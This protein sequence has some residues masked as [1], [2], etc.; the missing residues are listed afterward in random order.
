MICYNIASRLAGRINRYYMPQ[1]DRARRPMASGLV[2]VVTMSLL[3][4]NN[5]WLPIIN[6]SNAMNNKHSLAGV[7]AGATGLPSFH[8]LDQP[9][10]IEL[11]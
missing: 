2:G 10:H 5:Y 11:Q 4:L 9:L 8:F 3:T 1:S 7:L 6:N